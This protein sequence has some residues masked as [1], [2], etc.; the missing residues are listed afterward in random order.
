MVCLSENELADIKEG[1]PIPSW[2]FLP[3]IMEFL[4]IPL[5]VKDPPPP[6]EDSATEDDWD[7]ARVKQHKEKHKKK[8][9][10]IEAANKLAADL[11]A[12]KAERAQKRVTAIEQGLNLEELGL[13]DSEEEIII[14]DVS[15]DQ[16]VL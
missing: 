7:E 3:W 6:E 9:K 2:K 8:K 4:G 15:I 1:K 10:E 11:A 12:A 16:L 14:E 5:R 13:L